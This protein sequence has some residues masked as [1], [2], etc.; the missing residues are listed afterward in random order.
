M[1]KQR[2]ILFCLLMGIGVHLI[3]QQS[4]SKAEAIRQLMENNFDIRLSKND[5]KVAENNTNLLN[6]GYLPTLSGTAGITYNSDNINAVFRDGNDTNI[7]GAK[8]DSR[9]AGL[10]L[11]YV[12]FD[13]F[14]RKYNMER[15]KEN[16]NIAQLNAKATLETTLFTLFNAYY[17]V[18]RNQLQVESLKE[19]LEISKDRLVR[20]NYGFDYGRNSRLDVSNAEV[21]INNDSISYL[22][23]IQTLGNA[24]RNLNLVLANGIT[25]DFDVDTTL[26]FQSNLQKT[27]LTEALSKGNVQLALARAGILI[28]EYDEQINKARF[29]PTLSINGAY[30]YRLGNNNPASFLTSSTTKGLSYG[31]NLSW[32]LFDGGAAQT[33][34]KNTRVNRSSQELL[35]EQTTEQV[36]L[37]FE[38]AWA[39]YENRLFNVRAQENNLKTNQL[40]FERTEEQFRLGRVTSIDFRTAQSNLLNARINLIQAKYDA[41]LAELTLFQLAGKIQ[42]ALF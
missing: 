39:D 28:T 7:N 17:D 36:S 21:D 29:L 24:K 13:G 34:V 26:L 2:T 8:S 19:T 3:A 41:K 42:D 40:N 20:T 14:N 10:N 31:A 15:N 18:A 27:E 35:L 25:D 6:S 33:A 32:N 9:T 5:I 37:N 22:N 12:L 38:N 4:L 11:N 30:N 23:A 1:T 16:L